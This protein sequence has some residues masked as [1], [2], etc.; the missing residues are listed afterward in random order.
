ML[1]KSQ[2]EPRKNAAKKKYHHKLGTGGYAT[3]MPKWHKI[4][5]ALLAKGIIQ[6]PIRDEWEQRAR[7]FFLANESEYDNE[8]GDL[9]CSDGIKIPR[10]TWLKVVKEIKEGKNKGIGR[11]HV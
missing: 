4:E 3:A 2:H 7:I 10:E 1:R 11:A 8:T 6:E 5:E 9:V